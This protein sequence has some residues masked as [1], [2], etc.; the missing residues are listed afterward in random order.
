MGGWKWFICALSTLA[1][2]F[3]LSMTWMRVEGEASTAAATDASRNVPAA[4]A[5]AATA[6][7]KGTDLE[8][9]L[10]TTPGPIPRHLVLQRHA[11]LYLDK[12]LQPEFK[13]IVLLTAANSAYMDFLQNWE[14]HAKRLAL[15]WVVL[16][17]DQEAYQV[18]STSA[19]VLLATGSTSGSLEYLSKGFNLM[20]LNT[21]ATVF[22]VMKEGFDVVFTDSDNVFLSDPFA[23]GASLGRLIRSQRYDYVYQ[24]NWP[25]PRVYSPATEVQ[26][27]NT[28]FYYASIRKVKL[29][30]V[31]WDAVL[32]ECRLKPNLDGQP[33]FWS[34]LRRL[35][36]SLAPP[37]FRICRGD[38]GQDGQCNV[39]AEEEILDYCEMDPFEH[40]TGWG[41]R[42]DKGPVSYHA[43]FKV[44]RKPKIAALT[45]MGVW[46]P[47][48]T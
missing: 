4:T 21:L 28:G 31:L 41:H 32:K 47:T 16:A 1:A 39:T 9:V 40:R 2:A 36:K 19:R 48:C 23:A 30:S 38:A 11:G 20:S 25:G 14:C 3:S 44:G 12:S 43:N 15:D 35:R 5:T 46:Q 6:M 8:A 17:L 34:A 27:G 24:L 10:N 26:E 18:L 22:E 42:D 33:N 45:G 7:D 29:L 37:C 13:D